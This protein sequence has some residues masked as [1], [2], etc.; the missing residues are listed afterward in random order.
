M[1]YKITVHI[2]SIHGNQMAAKINGK[3]ILDGNKF[4]FYAI[5]FGRIGGHNV[6]VKISKNTEKILTKSDY[7]INTVIE[8]LQRCLIE[9]NIKLPEG[10]KLDSF[11]D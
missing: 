4:R 8:K 7:D 10:L 6:G 11:A 5:A 3:F 1:N 9:G 2:N